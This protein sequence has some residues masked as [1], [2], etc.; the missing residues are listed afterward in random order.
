MLLLLLLVGA[1]QL[2]NDTIR[3]NH[4]GLTRKV[5]RIAAMWAPFALSLR[6]VGAERRPA[7]TFVLLAAPLALLAD[8]SVGLELNTIAQVLGMTLALG[9][10]VAVYDG[11]AAA[12]VRRVSHTSYRYRLYPVGFA[13]A[14]VCLA[15]S[16][17][18][19]VAPGVVYGLVAGFVFATPVTRR[20]EGLAYARSSATLLGVAVIAFV[21]HG[22]VAPDPA[23]TDVSALAIILDTATAAVCVAGLQTTLVQLLPM[24]YVNGEKVAEWSRPAW[25]GLLAVGMTLYVQLVVRPNQQQQSWGSVW[26]AATLMGAALV[27]WCW[28]L[29]PSHRDPDDLAGLHD[30]ALPVAGGGVG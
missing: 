7:L 27:F 10:I 26:L 1:A 24:R 19:R 15:L 9:I 6:G 11:L 21:L 16:R 25:F 23:A 17:L 14:I 20:D 4:R 29:V 12:F 13:V 3:A 30:D 8:P 22:Y 28:Y 18:L 5:H 2:F